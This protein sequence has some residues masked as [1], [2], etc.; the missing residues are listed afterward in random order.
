[1][2]RNNNK[3]DFA[4]SIINRVCPICGKVVDEEIIVNKQ[5]TEKAAEQVRELHGKTVGYSN[6]ACDKCV[7]Y[8]DKAVFCIEIDAEKS[9]KNNPYRT[10]RIVGIKNDIPFVKDHE[11]FIITTENGVKF[12]FI[13]IEAGKQLNMFNQ[14]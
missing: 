1:M 11:N 6:K 14:V 5:L 8:A 9:D 12:M 2:S 3:V 7:E 4:A 10:G 13:D